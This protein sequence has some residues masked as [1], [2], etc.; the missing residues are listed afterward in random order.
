MTAVPASPPAPTDLPVVLVHGLRVSGAALHRIAASITDR[1][2]RC[3]DLPGHGDRSSERFTM[4]R[5]VD[6]VL[7]AVDDVGGRALVAGMSLG[8]YVAMASG[9]ADPR[10]VPGLMVMCATTQPT[11]LLAAPFRLFGAATRFLPKEAAAVSRLLTR[12]AV[13]RSVSADMEAGGLALH[14]I[15]DVVGELAAFDALAAV[16]DYSGAIEFVNGAQDPFRLDERRFVAAAADGRL[17]VIPSASHLFPLIQPA[18]VG[19]LIAE[20]AVELGRPRFTPPARPASDRLRRG[21]LSPL[22]PPTTR[23]R[24]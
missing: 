16:G 1:E 19:R 2:T 7:D 4:D 6:A 17:R 14:S 24:R 20:Q 21:P 15:R 11:T 3:P 22:P 9:S 13:G 10:A 8:G 23:P 5:A 18:L 12:V